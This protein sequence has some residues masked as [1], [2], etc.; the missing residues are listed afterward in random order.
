MGRSDQTRVQTCVLERQTKLV[1]SK[2]KYVIGWAQLVGRIKPLHDPHHK[3]RPR[4]YIR[5]ER[6]CD[7]VS[8]SF[9][10][11]RLTFFGIMEKRFQPLLQRAKF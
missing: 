3:S 4:E 2:W 1:V 7:Q 9:L 11:N 5:S 6:N 10:R 8:F